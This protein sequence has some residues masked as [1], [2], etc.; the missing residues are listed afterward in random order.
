MGC[1]LAS[2]MN[3]RLGAVFLGGAL[4]GVI[5]TLVSRVGAGGVPATGAL[6][7]AGKFEDA[8]GKPVTGEHALQ[9]N[10]W[11]DAESKLPLCLTEPKKQQLDGGYFSIVLPDNCAELVH[12]HKNLLSE[13]LLDGVSMGKAKL[14]AVPYALE[15]THA[16]SADAARSASGELQTT[17]D[18]LSRK[19][20]LVTGLDTRSGCPPE[21]AIAAPLITVDFNLSRE[22]AV[23]ITG[24]M[25]RNYEGRADLEIMVDDLARSST[26]AFTGVPT[27]AG[28]TVT[29][30]AVLPKGD[31][32]AVLRGKPKYPD[33]PNIWGCG[34]SYGS[35]DVLIFE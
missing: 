4:I 25:I 13:V 22:T 3:K 27:W 12:M 11:K 18:N 34:P 33:V 24:Q 21:G 26:I 29:W 35:L 5:G 14:G 16:I 17:V 23:Q 20:R 19:T 7:Y 1:T 10:L 2:A 32:V 9:V 30:S 6:R 31:H 8:E 15:A 28:A